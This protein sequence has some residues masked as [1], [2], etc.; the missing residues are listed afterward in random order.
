M[1][2]S[3][4]FRDINPKGIHIY[5]NCFQ[6]KEKDYPLFENETK[7][8]YFCPVLNQTKFSAK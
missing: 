3:S 4:F 2:G 1:S 7:N 5:A 6:L 8:H